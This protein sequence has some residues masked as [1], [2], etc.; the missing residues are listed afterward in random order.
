MV[1]LI[2]N[3]NFQKDGSKHFILILVEAER[4][5]ML[6]FQHNNISVHNYTREIKSHV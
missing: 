3:I 4:N 6:C 5:L 2:E 1:Q